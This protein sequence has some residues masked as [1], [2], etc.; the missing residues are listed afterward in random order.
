MRCVNIGNRL[1]GDG[2]PTYVILEIARTY[3]NF[4]EAADLISIAADHGASA[5]KIQSI[6]AKELMVKNP[7]TSDYVKMLEG[8]ERSFEEHLFLKDLC[9][10]NGIDFLSTPEGPTMADLLE[11]LDT[12][13]YKVSS[14]N[15][16]YYELLEKLSD[17]GKPVIISTGMGEDEEIE[18]TI[19]LLKNRRSDIVLLHCSSTY[20]TAPKNSNLRNISYLRNK[21]KN[22]IGYSDHTVGVLAPALAVSLGASVIEKHFT[23]DRN[24]EGADHTVGVDPRMLEDMMKKIRETEKML[25]SYDRILCEKEKEIRKSK[26]RK[27]VLSH[28]VLKGNTITKENLICLQTKSKDGIDCKYIEEI[29][30]RKFARRAMEK[31]TVLEWG[32]LD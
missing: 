14:L 19:E 29:D 3:N 1:V 6:L 4:R 7:H 8:L 21:Y 20:P 2:H 5:I 15:L 10:K 32:L 30:G 24:Q 28:G 11:K 12:P 25:G 26:R 27:L 23:L 13:A 18:K 31:N 22:V 9:N 16:V 17:T